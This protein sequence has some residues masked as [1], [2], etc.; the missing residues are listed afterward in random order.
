MRTG[1]LQQRNKH[2]AHREGAGNPDDS[3]HPHAVTCK[4]AE[5]T[6]KC[7]PVFKLAPDAESGSHHL[8]CLH[9][10]CTPHSCSTRSCRASSPAS[11]IATCSM[12]RTHLLVSRTSP[13]LCTTNV[14]CAAW[15]SRSS[16]SCLSRWS[17]TY[18]VSCSQCCST[19]R[20]GT[21]RSCEHSS[22]FHRFFRE[23]SSRSCGGASS[24]RMGWGSRCCRARG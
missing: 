17:Q 5:G 19:A 20:P 24:L 13:S 15:A 4:T 12:P 21:T 11:P 8:R 2:A 9:S 6:D 18:S 14:S 16:W 7:L 10:C 1:P 3:P 22:S 23:S